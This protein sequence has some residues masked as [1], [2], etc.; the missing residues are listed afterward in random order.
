MKNYAFP[1][2]S[3][4]LGQN[5]EEN[6]EL[7]KNAL[8]DDIWMHLADGPSPHVIIRVQGSVDFRILRSAARILKQASKKRYENDVE[9][10]WCR[11]RCITP[12][13]VPGQVLIHGDDF[14]AFR[15]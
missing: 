7:I 12:S 13:E 1:K 14:Q 10:I 5:R 15:L 6:T 8:P 9:M 3:I 2:F 4:V 11:V